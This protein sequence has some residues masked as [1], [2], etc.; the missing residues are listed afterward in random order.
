MK[1]GSEFTIKTNVDVYLF[2]ADFTYEDYLYYKEQGLLEQVAL[3][4]EH[5]HN[6]AT[7][8]GL[9]LIADRLLGTTN[10]TTGAA[11]SHI[12]VGSASTAATAA[13]TGVTTIVGSRHA[14]TY[15]YSFSTGQAHADTFFLSSENN[16]TIRE[17]SIHN[18]SSSGNCA[19]HYVF[20]SNFTKSASN[21]MTIAWTITLTAVAD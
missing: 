5:G 21:T 13:D 14:I 1:A 10:N 11:L 12:E 3:Q 16:G 4:S 17:T 9:D 8:V 19:A 20:G 6:L 2:P 7:N 18:A 15:S